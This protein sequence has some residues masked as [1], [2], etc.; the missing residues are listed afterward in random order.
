MSHSIRAVL[1]LCL[2]AGGLLTTPMSGAQDEADSW[3]S[4]DGLYR[5]RY[6]SELQPITINRMHR[7]TLYL[8]TSDGA[9]VDDAALSVRGGMPEH[10]HGL[11]T[12][13]RVTD[14]LGDG[15]YRLEG[16]RF[17]M[18]GLWEIEVRIEAEAGSDT[19]L[20]SLVL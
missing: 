12:S 6:T 20:I 10:D 5:I 4:R 3:V 19:A 8:E 13:P 9:A 7:W 11:P 1:C 18:Q 15:R 14:E 2:L 16:V 17:H